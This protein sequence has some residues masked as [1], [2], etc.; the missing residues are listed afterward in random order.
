MRK[1]FWLFTAAALLAFFA[2]SIGGCGGS[3]SNPGRSPESSP[4]SEEERSSVVGDLLLVYGNEK[5]YS[6]MEE[7]EAEGVLDKMNPIKMFICITDDEAEEVITEILAE[8][9]VKDETYEK[10]LRY[11]VKS[12]MFDAEKLKESY[13]KEETIL[14]A[15]PDETFINKALEAAGLTGDYVMDEESSVDGRLELYAFAK[16]TIGERTH[17]FTYSAACDEAI[18]ASDNQEQELSVTTGNSAEISGNKF[19]LYDADGNV[20]VSDDIGTAA[21]ADK[22]EVSGEPDNDGTLFTVERWRAFYEWCAALTD[23]AKEQEVTASAIEVRA[24]ADDDLTKISQ[25]QSKTF[26]FPGNRDNYSPWAGDE[27]KVNLRRRNSINFNVYACHSYRYGNDYY[28]VLASGTTIPQNFQDRNVEFTWDGG[29][30]D[31]VNYLTGYT[32]SFGFETYLINANWDDNLTVDEVALEKHVPRNINKGITHNEGMSW[33]LGGEVGV[34]KDGPSAKISA[35]IS[36]NSSKT[37]VTTEYEIQNK[38]MQD[39]QASAE[40]RA[41][42]TGPEQ[43]GYHANGIKGG[44]WG[45]NATRASFSNLTFDAQWVWRVN[46]SL[47]RQFSTGRTLPMRI[48]CK[49]QEGF[50]YGKGWS[51]FLPYHW[52]EGRRYPSFSGMDTMYL[53]MPA[54]CWVSQTM[55]DVGSEGNKYGG[56]D[57]LSEGNWEIINI[58][59]WVHFNQTSGSAT[60]DTAQ[61]VRFE[62]D[63]NTGG[64]RDAQI[65]FS[66]YTGGRTE[67]KTIHIHQRS[68]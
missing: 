13:E 62:V 3:S 40:W 49:W 9:K 6:M 16:R 2:V 50:C 67:T 1:V 22:L 7:L 66:M 53:D 30:H 41:D 21:S 10:I 15:Y 39:K 60:G 26:E 8:E 20:I 36:F 55:Y 45:V 61:P 46:K 18:E 63:E 28:L 34:N 24:A 19:F 44:R 47:W 43:A 51:L 31:T 33:N 29:D 68:R 65:T 17:T 32:G 4:E 37:W 27:K 38:V 57:L 12:Y 48:V 11:I 58:P 64:Q 56:L 14:L 52:D 23:W 5:Y 25:A 42:V 59:D 54:H 35:G